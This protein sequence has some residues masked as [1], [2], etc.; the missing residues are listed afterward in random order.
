MSDLIHGVYEIDSD[1]HIGISTLQLSQ[2]IVLE[3][4]IHV[5]E[6]SNYRQ[7]TTDKI[8]QF[9]TAQSLLTLSTS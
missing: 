7:T 8:T 3:G 9:T 4:R 1:V 5:S 2:H 6:S